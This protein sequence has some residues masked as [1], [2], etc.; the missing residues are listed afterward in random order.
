ML[1]WI[2]KPKG[3]KIKYVILQVLLKRKK[4]KFE[5]FVLSYSRAKVVLM[6]M[7]CKII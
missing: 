5:T 6:M 3:L 2:Q 1:L 7:G 4:N